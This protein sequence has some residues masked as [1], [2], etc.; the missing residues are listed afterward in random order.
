MKKATVAK[1]IAA[2]TAVNEKA[3]I[4]VRAVILGHDFYPGLASFL[5][6]SRV[7]APV[8]SSSQKTT[9]GFRN[10]SSPWIEPRQP[11]PLLIPKTSSG[12]SLPLFS[13][14]LLT[15]VLSVTGKGNN[16]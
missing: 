2:A 7:Q 16:S 8:R 4:N 13:I 15:S 14:K 1:P 12:H 10:G 3:V 11:A 5:A 6:H 9:S